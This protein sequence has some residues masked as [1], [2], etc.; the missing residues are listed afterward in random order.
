VIGI[1]PTLQA[2]GAV[3]LVIAIVVWVTNPKLRAA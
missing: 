1:S 3:A 2:S